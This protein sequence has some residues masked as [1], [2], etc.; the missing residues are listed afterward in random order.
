[1][2]DDVGG[3]CFDRGDLPTTCR[4]LPT[5]PV[6]DRSTQRLAERSC[7]KG[8]TI[9]RNRP[10]GARSSLG[11]F[12]SHAALHRA[13]QNLSN[14][15]PHHGWRHKHLLPKPW[16]DHPPFRLTRSA[17]Q[18]GP[19]LPRRNLRLPTKS[20]STSPIRTMLRWLASHRRSRPQQSPPLS[21]P[22]SPPD[23]RSGGKIRAPRQSERATREHLPLPYS[24][25]PFSRNNSTILSAIEQLLTRLAAL[26]PEIG[27]LTTG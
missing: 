21:L 11:R 3:G 14:W 2:T 4:S 1:M 19:P 26:S 6:L 8:P 5:P 7:P 25:R 12:P 15:L 18:G 17:N 24:L 9:Y 20:K 23:G 27:S 16:T 10:S 13:L 22:T